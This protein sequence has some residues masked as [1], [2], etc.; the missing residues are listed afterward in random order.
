MDLPTIIALSISIPTAGAGVG[1]LMA[2]LTRKSP[3]PPPET[4]KW[5]RGASLANPTVL[6]GRH[7]RLY[8]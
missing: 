6:K 5:T 3:P 8:P 1:V 4:P 7:G 2:T